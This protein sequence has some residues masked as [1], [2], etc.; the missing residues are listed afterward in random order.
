MIVLPVI[1]IYEVRELKMLNNN[2]Q[3]PSSVPPAKSKGSGNK[4]GKYKLS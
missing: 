4:V 3:Y 2:L 1:H